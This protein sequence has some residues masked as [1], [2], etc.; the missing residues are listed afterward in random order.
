[1]ERLEGNSVCPLREVTEGERSFSTEIIVIIIERERD[2][3]ALAK[4]VCDREK[5]VSRR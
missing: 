3:V 4:A 1:M 5:S 2:S